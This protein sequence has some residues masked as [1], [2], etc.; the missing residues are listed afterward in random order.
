MAFQLSPGVLVSEKDLTNVVPAVSS[1]A[2][3]FVGNFVWGPVNQIK[4]VASENQLVRDFG[5]PNAANVA[6]FFTAANFLGYGNN[7]QL[8]RAV[9]ASAK[10]A[11]SA[12][13]AVL[14]K[15]EDDYLANFSD[16]SQA[17]DF[18]AKCPGNF[19]NSLRVSMADSATFE[20]WEYKGNFDSAPS[21]SAASLASNVLNDE[22]HI[23]VLDE[24][25]AFTGTPGSVLEKFAFVSKQPGNKK[26]D[27][28]NNYYKDVINSQSKYVWWMSHPVSGTSST[29]TQTNNGTGTIV[30]ETGSAAV[31][32][33]GTAFTTQIQTGDVLKVGGVT[34][35]TVAS[36]QSNTALTL[37]ANAAIEV[38]STAN[39]TF[40]REVT[41]TSPS[42]W[43]TFFVNG[44]YTN[45][46]GALDVVLSGGVDD[47]ASS[48]D[49]ID[50]Y[51]LFANKELVDVSLLLTGAH[52]VTVAK[53]AI[54][55]IAVARLDCMVF[56]SPPMA[57]V[58]NNVGGELNAVTDYR[59]NDLGVNTSY[60]VMDSGWKVQYNRYSDTYVNVP[61][62]ADTA[63]RPHG[64]DK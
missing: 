8:V 61:L 23:I 54:D 53:H 44:A 34:V 32:G 21:T 58:Y 10:N 24:F 18:A 56:V 50:A 36:I 6:D 39:F 30:A 46:S 49:L 22:L 1:T 60:A 27:G 37:A 16:G 45:L 48:G 33:T 3:G 12:G 51:D 31:T 17:S 41:T 9:G 59:N 11:V 14:I 15:N 62:N 29:T 38:A 19:G 63:L 20:S 5:K 28:S 25:G 2:G 7:L 57:A 64:S 13:G 52:D 40:S 42:N 35:G 26:A 4:T 47:L 55:N 43:G